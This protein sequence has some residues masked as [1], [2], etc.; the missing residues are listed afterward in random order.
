[1]VAKARER[2]AD[3]DATFRLA[4]DAGVPIVMGTDAGTPFN[5]HG[6]N[7]EELAL[8]VE[9]GM[10]SLAAIVASTSAAARALGRDDIG[11][12]A[13]GKLADV[14]VWHGDPLIDITVL[15]QTPL[16]VFLG[17]NRVRL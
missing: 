1:M 15:Q 3:R 4:L 2:R 8:M 6:E 7:A 12:L 16:A 9:L 13:P 5:R 17:G 14:A 11:A 10:S